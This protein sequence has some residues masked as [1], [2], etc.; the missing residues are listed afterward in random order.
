[1]FAICIYNIFNFLL[2]PLYLVI[3]LFRITLGKDTLCSFLHKLSITND[4]RP[5]GK[6]IWL[7]AASV[8]ESMISITL[9]NA[10]SKKHQDYHF[11][12]TTGTIS[13]ANIIKKSL[14]KNV[15][16][17]FTPIDNYFVVQHFLKHWKPDL[18]IFIESELWPCLLH[19]AAKNF[20][21][22]LVNARLSDKSYHR[23]K[24]HKWF[25][26]IITNS[27]RSIVV[28]S[29]VDLYKYQ[30][31]NCKNLMNFGNLKFANTAL[32]VNDKSLLELKKIFNNKKIFVASSTHKEDET[33]IFQIIRDLRKSGIIT[34]LIVR[35]PYR[36]DELAYKCDQLGLKYSMRSRDKTPSLDDDLYIVDS[37]GELGLFY[38]L[39]SIVFVGGS[40]RHGGHNLLEPAYF[41][42]VII[43]GPDM[44][45]F[46]NIATDMIINKAA[47]QIKTT[48]ALKDK[49]KFFA[50]DNAIIEANIY[51]Q[52]A[53]KFV[54]N[55]QNIINNYLRE[56]EKLLK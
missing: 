50:S 10:L 20:D 18:G 27:F 40:F 32:D 13:S 43:L 37:F 31:L 33:V 46:Q 7:H 39:A 45:N 23:W 42:N 29:E 54:G 24:K 35:H 1:M 5:K 52:N 14:T 51:K 30:K 22:I 2:L 8:G 38:S 19:N 36:R 11:L 12:I 55:R 25:F 21:L 56:R 15:T 48:K 53:L 26:K 4:I 3:I 41:N 44:S 49:I 28:Q 9:V 6:L 47:L 34:I 16:H 17:Q